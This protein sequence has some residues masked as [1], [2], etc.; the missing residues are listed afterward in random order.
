MLCLR[1]EFN[2]YLA[3][4]KLSS[5]SRARERSRRWCRLSLALNTRFLIRIFFVLC[6]KVHE[7]NMDSICEAKKIDAVP[8]A[9][10]YSLWI[11]TGAKHVVSKEELAAE[12]NE[13]FMGR[14]NLAWDS[15]VA[16]E[17]TNDSRMMWPI[18]VHE[19]R[20]ALIKVPKFLIR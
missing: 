18:I 14:T 10:A 13:D 5:V 17:F 15:T 11:Q 9:R 6:C 7:L 3:Y 12:L 19:I 16:L 8:D 2:A 1:G 4:N 20:R